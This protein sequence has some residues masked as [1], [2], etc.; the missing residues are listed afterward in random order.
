MKKKGYY[1]IGIGGIRMSALA[2]YLKAQGFDIWGSDMSSSETIHQLQDHGIH[3]FI[4]HDKKN[5]TTILSKCTIVKAVKSY[6]IPPKHIEEIELQ[7]QGIDVLFDAQFIGGLTKKYKTIGIAGTSGKTTTTGIASKLLID[8]KYDPHIIIG[9]KAKFLQNK[10]YRVGGNNS[11]FILEADEYKD[12]FLNYH[13]E[14]LLLPS[15]TYDHPDYFKTK[16]Q[17]WESFAKAILNTQKTVI[18]DIKQTNFSNIWQIAKKLAKET[19]KPLPTLIDWRKNL[20][21]VKHFK[22]YINTQFLQEDSAVVYTLGKQLCI[23][24]TQTQQS[25]ESYK[26]VWR[27]FEH[28]KDIKTNNHQIS[29][30]SDYAHNPEKLKFCLQALYD[31]F[32]KHNFII[33]FQPHQYART[34]AFF[35]SFV[36]VLQNNI[37]KN[38]TLF[39]MDIYKSRDK[40]EDI[41]AVNSQMLVSKINRDNVRYSGDTTNTRQILKTTIQN[42]KTQTLILI[43]GAG[44]IEDILK[45]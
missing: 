8:S 12:A 26:G 39:I 35:D 38:T 27:R 20:E 32:K 16:Y 30:Y 34:K 36:K 14:Y 28:K 37:R 21:K 40:L 15:I 24:A 22:L 1:F 10:G 6:A 44:N 19:Q 13:F 29:I 25:L 4:G 42:C 33:F 41:R 5:V 3:V 23:P 2:G 17:Y 18:A 9:S 43:I 7:E 45:D 31:S 11:L